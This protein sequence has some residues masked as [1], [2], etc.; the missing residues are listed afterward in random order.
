[1][2]EKSPAW[3]VASLHL[4]SKEKNQKKNPQQMVTTDAMD[5][6]AGK[7]ILGNTRY[8]D[9]KNKRS[10]QPNRNH[11]S[12]ITREEI[13][14]HASEL[15]VSLDQAGLV[16]SNIELKGIHPLSDLVD[17]YI[18]IGESAMLLVY[19]LRVPCWQMDALC[20]GLQKNMRNGRQGIIAEVVR[21]GHIRVG[22]VV[23][24]MP[25]EETVALTYYKTVVDSKFETE[26][27]AFLNRKDANWEVAPHDRKVQQF[28]F[29]YDYKTKTV[30]KTPTTAIPEILQTLI[31]QLQV[32]WRDT[33]NQ[34]IV[35]VYEKC[36][37]IDP[38]TD[39]KDFGDEISTLSLLSDTIMQFERRDRIDVFS[40]VFSQNLERYSLL[41]MRGRIRHDYLHS[42]PPVSSRR[43]SITFRKV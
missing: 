1:M 22:D 11:V 41:V 23:K 3:V 6:V 29:R 43:V 28:G 24:E 5:L 42:I 16:R 35:N 2:A 4:H 38:H 14:E 18:Q 7:G 34:V 40:D 17:K 12:L 37:F 19:K 26:F 36:D 30:A 21:S 10:G 20:K 9:T 15:D 31:K 27:M 13:Q 32:H 39:H 33:P 25:K 8:F